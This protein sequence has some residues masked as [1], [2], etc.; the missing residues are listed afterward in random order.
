MKT[1][2]INCAII[3][4]FVSCGNPHMTNY[5][6][7]KVIYKIEVTGNT[8]TVDIT[9]KINNIENTINT[10]LPWTYAFDPVI[11]YTEENTTDTH[12]PNVNWDYISVISYTE[13]VIDINYYRNDT[14]L[15]KSVQSF[16]Y[17]EEG[18]IISTTNS[19]FHIILGVPP[20]SHPPI[21]Y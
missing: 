6:K 9:Y 7:E 2:F 13:A 10:T 5:I 17:D 3:C 19:M 11:S 20:A 21:L 18:N 1:M 4:L 14:L 15:E 12:Y 8:N 16:L